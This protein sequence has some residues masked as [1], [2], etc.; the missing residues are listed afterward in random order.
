MNGE[1]KVWYKSKGFWGNAI[2]LLGAGALLVGVDF[3]PGAQS[4]VTEG[5]LAGGTAISVLLG[6]FGRIVAKA[7]LTFFS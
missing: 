1:T 3:D 5:L 2:G 6:L 4:Q 7:R